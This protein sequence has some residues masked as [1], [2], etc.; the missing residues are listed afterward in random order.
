MLEDRCGCPSQCPVD[1]AVDDDAGEDVAEVTAGHADGRC[2]LAQDVERRHD[3]DRLREALQIIAEAA[4]PD[5]G[6]G[7][8]DEDDE[9]PSG[10]RGEVRGG[11]AQPCQA[12][13]VRDDARREQRRDKRDQL[14][15]FRGARVVADEVVRRLHKHLSD[16][17]PL[18]DVLHLLQ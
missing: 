9:R 1:Q 3:E 4:G 17:L 12:D 6:R 8:H 5:L 15:E 10:F 7:D 14:V 2:E 13:E 16:R 18:G 11:A